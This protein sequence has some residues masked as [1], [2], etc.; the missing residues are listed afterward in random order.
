MDVKIKIQQNKKVD[1][2]G[3]EEKNIIQTSNAHYDGIAG[4]QA[5]RFPNWLFVSYFSSRHIPLG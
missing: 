5:L 1:G 4:K 3:E 2:K